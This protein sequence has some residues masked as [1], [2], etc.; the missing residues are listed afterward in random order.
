MR[1][2]YGGR[3]RETWT[4]GCWA[5]DLHQNV[6][7]DQC[8]CRC[9]S[10]HCLHVVYVTETNLVLEAGQEPLAGGWRG[11]CAGSFLHSHHW[12][13]HMLMTQTEFN[14]VSLTDYL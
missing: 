7:S 9:L 12:R 14:M 3:G 2:G 11:Q 1:S 8:Q 13:K 5:N 10:A 4:G 6:S